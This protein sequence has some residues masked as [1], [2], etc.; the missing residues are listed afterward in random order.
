MSM[1]WTLVVLAVAVA[2]TPLLDRALGRAA[3]WPLA[4]A[5]LVATAT[6][7]PAVGEAFAGRQESV[8]VPWVA[9]LGID[10]ALRADGLGIA[11][12]LIALGHP[13]EEPPRPQR[14]D[15]TMVHENRW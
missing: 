15:E 3:G 11:F 4:A 8:R 9:P 14:W 6:L 5:Y 2:S 12:C 1:V 10:F 13:A 7:W